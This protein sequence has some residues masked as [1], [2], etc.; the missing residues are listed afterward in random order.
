VLDLTAAGFADAKSAPECPTCATDLDRDRIPEFAYRMVTLK[1]APCARASC[2]P[3]YA[4]EVQVR[5]L[6]SWEGG[7][8]ER[9]LRDFIP[10][11]FDRLRTAKRD[12]ARARRARNKSDVCPL[13]AL[14]VAAEL[15]I[16]GQLIGEQQ[17]DALKGADAAMAGYSMGPC[18]RE[19]DLLGPSRTWGELR[20]ELTR[21]SLPKL[22]RRR[23]VAK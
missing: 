9:D 7:R 17:A 3:S 16:Y 8:F 12:A 22:E 13:N 1:V 4:L 18:E 21:V 2:G 20:E 6:E 23:Q 5:G 10:L 11:Y 14:K 19:Y 15:Y